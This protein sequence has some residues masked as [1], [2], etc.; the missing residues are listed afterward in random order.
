MIDTDL[1]RSLP[2]GEAEVFA[3]RAG[4]DPVLAVVIPELTLTKKGLRACPESLMIS[5]AP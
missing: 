5:G 1:R 4:R 2:S 3:H